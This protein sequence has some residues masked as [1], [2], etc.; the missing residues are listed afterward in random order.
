MHASVTVAVMYQ[1]DAAT[2]TIV[3]SVLQMHNIQNF[4]PSISRLV[5]LV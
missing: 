4:T 2:Q 5:P 1:E 3:V